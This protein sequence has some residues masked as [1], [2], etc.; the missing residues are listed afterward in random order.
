MTNARNSAP[1]IEKMCQVADL[2]STRKCKGLPDYP[3][4]VSGSAGAVVNDFPVICGGTNNEAN[5]K[6]CYIHELTPDNKW[7]L[8]GNLKTERSDHASIELQGKL[9][10]TGGKNRY[11]ETLS[12]STTEFISTT[13]VAL[14]GP[15]LPQKREKHCMVKLMDGKVMIL[16]GKPNTIGRSVIIYDPKDETFTDGPNMLLKR[17]SAAC[18]VFK[19][20]MHG[21]RPVVLIVGHLNTAEILDYTVKDATWEESNYLYNFIVN[22]Y[23]FVLC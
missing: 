3:L 8:L 9:W 17:D 4:P 23:L 13:G 20:L 15:E 2:Q 5:V 16:G 22:M 10:V 14:F 19:S 18:T 12:L 6:E 21:G 1:K 11:G 7:R